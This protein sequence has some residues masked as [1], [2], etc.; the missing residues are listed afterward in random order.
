MSL[1]LAVLRVDLLVLRLDLLVEH[2]R[3][4]LGLIELLRRRRLLRVETLRALVGATGDLPLRFE[5][6]ALR[7]GGIPLR[8]RDISLGLQDVDL[9]SDLV[10]SRGI[11]PTLGLELIALQTQLHGVNRAD[12]CFGSQRVSFLRLEG[13]QP[14][15][16]FGTDDNGRGLDVA[17][18]VGL[19]AGCA[20]TRRRWPPSTSTGAVRLRVQP[21]VASPYLQP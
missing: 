16:G 21:L 19:G 7:L 20:R 6:G 1:N 11:G 12:D 14:A 15:A 4:S 13:D 8:H 2:A 10:D 9:L 17:V 3:V 5:R 18:G